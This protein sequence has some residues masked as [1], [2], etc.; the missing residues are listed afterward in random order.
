MDWK[1]VD[2]E[3]GKP[4]TNPTPYRLKKKCYQPENTEQIPFEYSH[5]EVLAKI[6]NEPLDGLSPA[7]PPAFG[8][9]Y[10]VPSIWQQ[11]PYSSSSLS[12]RKYT[13]GKK[14]NKNR[15][16]HVVSGEYTINHHKAA[17]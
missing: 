16:K 1:H 10:K 11:F 12:L 2:Q 7:P 9:I 15:L 8:T 4:S 6:S 3:G 13:E 17:Q 5:T 14:S